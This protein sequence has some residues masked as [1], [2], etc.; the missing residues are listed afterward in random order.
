MSKIKYILLTLGLI[1]GFGL[2][3]MPANVSAA[4]DP[5]ANSCTDANGNAINS[6]L[7]TKTT[8]T[9]PSYIT[10]IVSGLLYILG[11]VSVI[12]IIIAG[13]FYTTSVGDP[14]MVE[15]AKNT[16]M[17]A[18]I[19]LVVALLSYAIV[20]FVAGQIKVTPATTTTETTQTTNTPTTTK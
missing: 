16:L 18:V 15:K 7:C 8:E 1:A 9:I 4:N 10:K 17:Y 19:G 3:V 11:V 14:K 5:L 12:V 13:V 20:S 2:A 6:P